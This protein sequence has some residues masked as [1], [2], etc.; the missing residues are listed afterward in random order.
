MV[1]P[2]TMWQYLNMKK[3]MIEQESAASW[4][5]SDEFH[6]RLRVYFYVVAVIVA[7]QLLWM[8]DH[9]VGVLNSGSMETINTRHPMELGFT[10]LQIEKINTD[11]PTE[12]VSSIEEPDSP[13]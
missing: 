8:I 1:L 11:G 2:S 7:S 9:S 4:V 5:C 3:R 10:P 12:S 13:V 6:S